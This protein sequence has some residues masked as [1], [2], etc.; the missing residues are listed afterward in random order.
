M[1]RKLFVQISVLEFLAQL[2]KQDRDHLIKVFGCISD[3]PPEFADF[4]EYDEAG[5]ALNGHVTRRFHIS[6]WDDF[7]DRHLKIMSVTWADR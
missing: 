3:N 1:S 2:R 5:R 4:L 6:F 7:A